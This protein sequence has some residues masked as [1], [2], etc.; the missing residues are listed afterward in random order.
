[1]Q[2]RRRTEQRPW[3]R[4]ATLLA[5][6][7]TCLMAGA[8]LGHAGE[9]LIDLNPKKL[10]RSDQKGFVWDPEPTG[11]LRDGSNDCFDGALELQVNGKS[12]TPN[13]SKKMTADARELV[14]TGRFGSLE[15]TRRIRFD[16]TLSAARYVEIFRNLGSR[17]IT[18]QAVLST[19]LGG[20]A[21][22]TVTNIDNPMSGGMF[23]RDEIGI[24]AEQRGGNRPSVLFVL[25][26]PGSPL[27][28]TI[29]IKNENHNF[30]FTWNVKVPRGRT[31]SL[32]HTIAQ[33]RYRGRPVGAALQAEFAPFLTSKWAAGLPNSVHAALA[34]FRGGG[35]GAAAISARTSAHGEI[36]A[37]AKQYD[38][39]RNA[40]AV[41]FVEA[42]K[43]LPGSVRGSK[44]RIETLRGPVEVPLADVAILKGGANLGRSMRLY[45]RNGEIFIGEAVAEGLTFVSKAGLELPLSPAGIDALF[46]PEDDLDGLAPDGAEFFLTQLDD[47]KLAVTADAAT[48]L[49]VAT[50]WGDLQVPLGDVI[51]LRY[52]REPRPGL[53]LLLNDGT[54]LPVAI[55]GGPLQMNSLRFG[56][57]HVEPGAIAAW[58]RHGVAPPAPASYGNVSGPQQTHAYLGGRAFLVG[59]MDVERLSMRAVSGDAPIDP[60]S[61]Q[62]ME[63]T[64]GG[65]GELGMFAWTLRTGE[66]VRGLLRDRLIPFVTPR[67][68]CYVPAMHLLG[69]RVAEETEPAGADAEGK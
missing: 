15:V 24:L 27:D 2:R 12:F 22:A 9:T 29:Q 17:E 5:V 35:P 46:L 25:S 26:S 57:I 10:S 53:W 30:K 37:L 6:G 67:G 45:L 66:T 39:E 64:G 18:V 36:L 49:D 43:P 62:H 63:R 40:D 69:Y 21:A 34:N 56:E 42:G 48:V 41:L 7:A 61:L 38:V 44:V 13:L 3:I 54:R 14:L 11:L 19:A 31:V 1:M 47:A 60:R 32:L 16:E 4:L 33:R 51:R 23:E 65:E 68:R 8:G 52:T 20:S 50:P 28:P 58:S 59:H 55:T